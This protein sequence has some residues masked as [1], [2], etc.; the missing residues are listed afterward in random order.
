MYLKH[1]ET[2]VKGDWITL[3]AK[4]FNIIKVEQNDEQ[5]MRIE[6]KDTLLKKRNVENSA[7]Q[8]YSNHIKSNRKK[9]RTLFMNSLNY[10]IIEP[11]KIW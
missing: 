9:Q 8:Q 2:F 5:I 3:L 11:S 10:N 1:I 7:F 4:D 6:K